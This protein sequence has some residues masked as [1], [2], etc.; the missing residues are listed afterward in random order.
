MTETY[1]WQHREP[2]LD[3]AIYDS[4]I[5]TFASLIDWRMHMS[6]DAN[7]VRPFSANGG[8]YRA[9]ALTEFKQ[10]I[11]RHPKA[12]KG[13]QKALSVFLGPILKDCVKNRERPII[14]P[15]MDK[16]LLKV[17]PRAYSIN[18]DQAIRYWTRGAKEEDHDETEAKS[19][20]NGHA[21]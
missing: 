5:A 18:Y 12:I 20:I 4:R 17:P 10:Y 8:D 21:T 1:L 13:Y 11:L 15:I 14:G 7:F 19:L 16:R 6:D 2:Y 3:G 9:D